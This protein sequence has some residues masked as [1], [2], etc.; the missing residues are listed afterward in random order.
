MSTNILDVPSVGHT[1]IKELKDKGVTKEQFCKETGFSIHFV[2]NII[3]G[4]DLIVEHHSMALADR[5]D[6]YFNK[7]SGFWREIENKFFEAEEM[8]LR[9]LNKVN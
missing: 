1:L 6:S 4:N 5:L 3:R 7:P 8:K 9:K 2:N